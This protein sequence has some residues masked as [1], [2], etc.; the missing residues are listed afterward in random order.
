[1]GCK[2]QQGRLFIRTNNMRQPELHYF[3]GLWY[4]YYTAGV[5]QTW[6]CSVLTC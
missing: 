2:Y 1:M 3:D 4:I 5:A 6:T